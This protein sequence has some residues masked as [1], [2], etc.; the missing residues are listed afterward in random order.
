MS[1][2]QWIVSQLGT[3]GQYPVPRSFHMKGE[4][5]TFYTEAWCRHGAGVLKRFPGRLRRLSNRYHADLPANRIVAFTTR[6]LVCEAMQYL[7]GRPGTSELLY[8]YH[9]RVGSAYGTAVARCLARRS[10]DPGVH[11]FLTTSTGSLEA[12]QH[13]RERGVLSVI[14]QLDPARVDHDMV[15]E[16]CK[17][18]PEWQALPGRVPEVYFERLKQEWETASLVLVNSNWSKQAVMKDGVPESKIIVVPLVYEPEVETPPAVRANNNRPL[19]VLWLGQV[20][21]RKGIPYLFEAARVLKNTRFTVAGHIGVSPSAIRSAPPNLTVMGRVHRKKALRLYAEA[22]VFVLPTLSDGFALTQL[23]AMARGLPVIATPNCG[24][25]V[26]HG[27]DGVIIPPDSSEALASAITKIDQDRPL[28]L[29]MSR[30]ACL[31]SQAYPL[32]LYR[33]QV[34]VAVDAL[35]TPVSLD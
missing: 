26:T 7:L 17:K 15:Y 20:I 29:E 28:L 33:E 22:D 13:T 6:T 21:L 30:N 35:R 25:V 14:Y 31:K 5:D 11:H 4:L 12:L 9:I 23:E 27:V 2:R 8:Q 19:H 16:E 3:L 34:N 10:L 24:D 32:P 1:R 18:W